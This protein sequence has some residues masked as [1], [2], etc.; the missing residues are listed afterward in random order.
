MSARSGVKGARCPHTGIL[1]ICRSRYVPFIEEVVGRFDHY[2]DWVHNAI[3]AGNHRAYLVRPLPERVFCLPD[4]CK[5]LACANV[6]H[7]G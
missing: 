4:L 2:C 7:R 3:G 5:R 6:L 1:I